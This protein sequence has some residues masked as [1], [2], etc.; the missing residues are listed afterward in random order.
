MNTIR[1]HFY[2]ATILTICF[3]KTHP[4]LL[5]HFLFGLQSGGFPISLRIK[6]L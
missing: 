6:I 4:I 1:K 2:V 5:F 3:P